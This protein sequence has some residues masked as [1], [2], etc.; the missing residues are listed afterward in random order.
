MHEV[1]PDLLLAHDPVQDWHT[2]SHRKASTTRSSTAVTI[3]FPSSLDAVW[4]YSP[5]FTR[6]CGLGWEVEFD[7]YSLSEWVCGNPDLRQ[8]SLSWSA[9]AHLLL[10]PWRECGLKLLHLVGV[11]EGPNRICHAHQSK[12]MF[13]IPRRRALG[14]QFQHMLLWIIP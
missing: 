1:A 13:K 9:A 4:N 8:I 3:Y 6:T 10:L 7:L 14:L 2:R 11:R 5:P 12:T